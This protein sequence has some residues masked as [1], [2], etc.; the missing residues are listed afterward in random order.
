MDLLAEVFIYIL[1]TRAVLHAPAAS[2]KIEAPD[3]VIVLKSSESCYTALRHPVISKAALHQARKDAQHSRF[4]LVCRFHIIALLR[5]PPLEF[6]AV[7]SP[8]TIASHQSQLRTPPSS[9]SCQSRVAIWTHR[10]PDNWISIGL[11]RL[12]AGLFVLPGSPLPH[13]AD[14]HAGSLPRLFLLPI[15][16][17]LYHRIIP[18]G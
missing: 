15:T 6:F 7:R 10:Q 8:P 18:L 17:D 16:A 4:P 3:S 14:Y 2:Q 1:S 5:P 9:L 11:K 12:V 13:C